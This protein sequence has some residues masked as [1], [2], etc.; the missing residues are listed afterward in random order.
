MTKARTSRCITFS[1]ARKGELLYFVFR[2]TTKQI[3]RDAISNM[4]QFCGDF[5]V[6]NEIATAV[7][8][9]KC[10]GVVMA[11]ITK[12][13]IDLIPEA[14]WP[15]IIA[16]FLSRATHREVT[17]IADYNKFLNT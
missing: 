12:P 4:S 2:N 5:I 15:I 13:R 9:G 10:F 3:V 17:Y 16:R 8:N 14:D 6:T 11:V 1:M 7:I